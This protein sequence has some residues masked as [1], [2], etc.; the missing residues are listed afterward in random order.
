MRTSHYRHLAR[1]VQQ[2][3]VGL[4]MHQL[5]PQNFSQRC[6]ALVLLG[7][8]VLAAAARISLSAVAALQSG[9]PSRETLRHALLATLP[10]Y[11][12]LL[13]RLPALLRTSIPRG[14]RKRRRR[15]PIAIDLHDVPYYIRHR[16]APEHV[17]KGQRLAGT[18]FK[19]QYATASL[20]RKGQYYVV[21][22]TPYDPNDDWADLV[23]RLLRQAAQNGFSPRYVLLDRSFWTAAVLRYLQQARYPFML[24]AQARGKKPTAPGGPT[25]TRRFFHG[26][27][28][29]TYS[30][31]LKDPRRQLAATVTIVVLR[32]NQAGRRRRH[33]RYAWV[34]GLWHMNLSALAWV[35]QS[36]RRR[37]RIE[38]SYR[39]MEEARGRTSSRNEGWRL[40]YMVLAGLLLNVWLDLRRQAAGRQGRAPK[41]W[42]WW[43]RLLVSLTFCLLLGTA[44]A[45]YQTAPTYHPQL[46]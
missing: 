27:A 18:C 44:D 9:F 43:N 42:Y 19:H 6:T 29:G 31:T 32:R 30:Y 8:L 4:L 28:T 24:P 5:K 11:Q 15:Y 46:E 34:Y 17:R 20:L 23:R 1:Q 26:C 40:W 10:D 36:Y 39:M 35:R 2:Q 38:S 41:E 12:T 16:P 25:S 37:F 7:C 13:H 3:T 33:G 45:D 14:L 21:A 22:F